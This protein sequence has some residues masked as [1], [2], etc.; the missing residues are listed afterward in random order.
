MLITDYWLG[1]LVKPMWVSLKFLKI[2]KWCQNSSKGY[3]YMTPN[4]SFLIICH[5][6]SNFYHMKEKQNITITNNLSGLILQSNFI[7]IT[8]RHVLLRIFCV[9]LLRIFRAPFTK[10]TFGRL[11][12]LFSY[13]WNVKEVFVIFLMLI[14][15]R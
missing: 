7:E 10:N 8:L 4:F 13:L 3:W 14:Q 1:W 6:G 15:I 2:R 9:N 5:L 11:L 12:L